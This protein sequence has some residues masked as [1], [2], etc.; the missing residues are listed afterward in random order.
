MHVCVHRHSSKQQQLRALVFVVDFAFHPSWGSWTAF[1]KC[2]ICKEKS[3]YIL[4]GIIHSLVTCHLPVT[5]GGHSSASSMLPWRCK[6]L[7]ATIQPLVLLC[8]QE[9]WRLAPCLGQNQASQLTSPGRKCMG[10]TC[11]LL[12]FSLDIDEEVLPT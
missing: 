8:W 1:Y 4:P 2:N 12:T 5:L 3:L 7:S 10:Y 11:V 9:A 6:L